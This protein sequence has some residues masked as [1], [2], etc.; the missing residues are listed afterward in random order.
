MPKRFFPQVMGKILSQSKRPTVYI[1]VVLLILQNLTPALAFSESATSFKNQLITFRSSSLQ[2]FSWGV[3][4]LN[5]DKDLY[6]VGE[7][8][9]F[10]MA[11]LDEQG[12][13]DC[14]A[15]LELLVFDELG[16]GKV[17]TS[18]NGGIIV[19]PECQIK[20]YTK[21][22]DFEASAMFSKAGKY[23]LVL[24]AKTK[25]GIR[26]IYDTVEVLS[27]APG[28]TIS[29][30]APTRVFP[31]VSYPVS[32]EIVAN[33]DFSGTISE[34]L[35]LAF[36]VLDQPQLTSGNISERLLNSI[37]ESPSQQD[38]RGRI[39]KSENQ[40]TISFSAD[41]KKG[42]TYTL[43]YTFDAP[44]ISP[45]FYSLGKIRFVDQ[46]GREIFAEQ[47]QWQLANDDAVAFRAA[48]TSTAGSG[49]ITINSPTGVQANDI[50]IMF[51]SNLDNVTVTVPG[52]WTKE[53][54]TAN[55]TTMHSVVAW[56]RATSTESGYSYTVTH[57]AGSS[58]VGAIAAFSGAST[59]GNPFTAT[60]T[61]A[62]TT[63][64][65]TITASGTN[66]SIANSAV[67]F[68]GHMGDDGNAN[69][70]INCTDPTG[71]TEIADIEDTVGSD[72]SMVVAWKL[73]TTTGLTGN[74]TTLFNDPGGT[75][76]NNG[77]LLILKPATTVFS[78]V[79][80]SNDGS[81]NIGSG[82]T[83]RLY[84][85]GVTWAGAASTTA[86]GAW[87]I[88]SSTT[89]ANL[90]VMTA[91]IDND[92]TDG[93][94]VW[95]TDGTTTSTIDIYGGSVIVRADVSTIS[96]AN[97]VTAI[98]GLG[99]EADMIY[100]TSSSNTITTN[101][102]VELH[103][104]SSTTYGPSANITT[105]GTGNL[106]AD[107]N[108]TVNLV[109]CTC[110]IGGDLVADSG[111][112]V[113][114]YQDSS[115]GGGD[116]TTS[117]TALVSYIGSPTL[118]VTGAGTLGGGSV[119]LS[120]YNLTLSGTGTS[121]LTSTA[122]ID[123]DLSV[124]SGREFKGTKNVTVSGG[125]ASGN[126]IVNFTGGTFEVRGTGYLGG[127]SNW[128]FNDLKIGNG[129][130]ATITATST[131][132]ITLQTLMV[133][134]TSSLDMFSKI[135][136]VLGTGT[137]V[138]ASGTVIASSSTISYQG[139][140]G[141]TSVAGIAYYNL[142]ISPAASS[143]T[144]QLD[145][146][147]T[148]ST[149]SMDGTIS[150]IEIDSVNDAIYAGT[151]SHGNIYKCSLSTG[152]TPINWIL[153]TD[154]PQTT[155]Y[156]IIVDTQNNAIFA[157]TYTFGYILRC[158]ISSGC[159]SIT[160]WPLATDTEQQAIGN[161]AIDS[162]S[163]QPAIYAAGFSPGSPLGK[164]LIYK[165][166]LS[167]AC[168]APSEWQIA[169]TTTASSTSSMVIDTFNQQIFIGT[170]VAA[171][172]A[173]AGTIYKCAFS[174]GCNTT[175]AWTIA[176]DTSANNITS[177]DIDPVNNVIFAGT[178]LNGI[179]YKCSLYTA[180]GSSDWQLATDTA[181][182]VSTIKA[183][184]V[185][186]VM[187][188][189]SYSDRGLFCY[190]DS[191]CGTNDWKEL[192]V[193]FV[194]GMTEI[195]F[196]RARDTI[197]TGGSNGTINKIN[198]RFE[199]TN[200]FSIGGVA[201]VTVDANRYNP[202]VSTLGN[203]TI[204]SG[205]TY[206]A[207]PAS[208]T[209]SGN[210][211][212][213]GTFTHNNGTVLFNSSSSEKTLFASTTF[214]N[215]GIEKGA[216]VAQDSFTV[217]NSFRITGGLFNASA[218]TITLIATNTPLTITKGAFFG[219]S[220]TLSFQSPGTTTVPFLNYYNL[221]LSP[222]TTSPTYTFATGTYWSVATDTPGTALFKAMG[223]DSTYNI[224]YAT[225]AFT[226]NTIKCFLYSGCYSP[227][228]WTL[229]T[230]TGGGSFVIGAFAYDTTNSVMYA[231]AGN[232]NMLKCS[233]STGCGTSN[234]SLATVTPSAVTS[235]AF[236]AVNG[237]IFAGDGTNGFIWKCLVSTGCASAGNWTV[238]TDTA[239]ITIGSMVIDTASSTIFAG[240]AFNGFIYKCTLSTLCD[241]A[242]EWTLATDTPQN[243]S[244][245]AF[246]SANNVLYAGGDGGLIYRCLSSTGCASA[247]NWTVATTTGTSN[248]ASIVYD[249][250]SRTLYAS[251][252]TYGQIYKCYVSTGCDS[253]GEWNL[254]VQ[255]SGN[256]DQAIL[257]LVYASTTREIYAADRF[258]YIYKT[259]STTIQTFTVSNNL[260][261][262][263]AA[264]TTVDLNTNDPELNIFGSLTIGSGDTFR[265][266]NI[267]TTTVGG[268]LT[269]TGT[270]THNN[271]TVAF[272]TSTATSTIS[273][274]ANTSFYNVSVT[275]PGKALA[276]QKHT[277]N[278]PTFTVEGQMVLV[279]AANNLI[280]VLSDTS[281]SKWLVYFTSSQTG[282]SYVFVKDSACA[283]G[284][285]SIP[286]T[287]TFTS[288]GN[289]DSCWFLVASSGGGGSGAI[290]AIEG[291]S[292]G[293]NTQ[294]GGGSSGG[295]GG[296]DGGSGG[297][298][299]QGGGGQGG[300]GGGGSP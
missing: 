48:S 287:A 240:T 110:T 143:P 272:S 289:N 156:D 169:T 41:F 269:I 267:S 163:S 78:G 70:A 255:L 298:G 214:Y 34:T 28:F 277:T 100:A 90:D 79:V 141:T 67:I 140:T 99:N 201:N 263:G 95:V 158:A 52:G 153:G 241:S 115:I 285:A 80:Y 14:N 33:K 89:L 152:C 295:S 35:P 71:L 223:Y 22:P 162:V 187:Y 296:S 21:R 227:T 154:T 271:G 188:V 23:Q 225:D 84:K 204:G 2:D 151:N 232:G 256:P 124:G 174:T 270:F 142:D 76:V 279:G 44:D 7:T 157:G 138:M 190:L 72:V 86:G 221:D 191:G 103:V 120:F 129:T 224:L 51:I 135:W 160:D 276:F 209:I 75:N 288:G 299:S 81:S 182:N 65:H 134:A 77:S 197:F 106:H 12:T 46:K 117:G 249:T 37:K 176:T 185:N 170:G 265:A 183:D 205:D 32:I 213:S 218:T 108:S 250:F 3:L 260:S 11:V 166:I 236:D 181:I 20:D 114:F 297:G 53:F 49:D 252:A 93:N 243:I 194:P 200:N 60:T 165:C 147:F 45:E 88:T 31:L 175:G 210:F 168:D 15:K 258:G 186:K 254:D 94:T 238:S 102:N 246:D 159:D 155:I 203:F 245:L 212:N 121:T 132:Q 125:D 96:N 126:G 148:V 137:P 40:Q 290:E 43:T 184:P 293:G 4:A 50:L 284:S 61:K 275:T 239:E 274:A 133:A 193:A 180:C 25:N 131:G 19:N 55:G 286:N 196:D 38:A 294:G 107:D 233:G 207:A 259:A 171:G 266:S 208:T 228:D 161:F 73:K 128:I 273:S 230:S 42:Q 105:Q 59:T 8:A 47:R 68:A 16:Y 146:G 144:Y 234:W 150:T 164:A 231:A 237:A 217:A 39:Q 101:S 206:L 136:N 177:M 282:M 139:T 280:R 219:N 192:P 261:L 291:G 216:Y 220:G 54:D 109:S 215:L 283:A 211:T 229:A 87:S 29:R 6:Q 235:M 66:V 179:I 92:S 98:A 248:I 242:G 57:T 10:A 13:M 226:S 127:S 149:S 58:I 113:N 244:T 56:K 69:A 26:T 130:N 112:A 104:W 17:L 1:A 116:I 85:N 119:S 251:N 262:N 173:Q 62:N 5:P 36:S 27:K 222:T 300:Q 195:A 198:S 91:Y 63:A 9:N 278:V 202:K 123:N 64:S 172:A 145:L 83:V 253:A 178:S 118:T 18:D 30:S 122:T 281:G 97:L 24:S 74:C 264:N 268:N 247:G 82:K 189:L 292:G 257:P 199:V 111:A 167:T